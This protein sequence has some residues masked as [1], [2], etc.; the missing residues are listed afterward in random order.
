M[1][2]LYLDDMRHHAD[3]YWDGYDERYKEE[4]WDVVRDFI[5]FKNYFLEIKSLEQMPTLISFDH[6]L[7]LGKT[8]YDAIKWFLDYCLERNYKIP[9]I[10]FHTGNPVGLRNMYEYLKNFLKHNPQLA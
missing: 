6:D 4:N 9:E 8:G 2:Y 7:G 10:L 5:D 3:S 1:N